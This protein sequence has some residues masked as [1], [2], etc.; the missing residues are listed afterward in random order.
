MQV[1]PRNP[2]VAAI[3]ERMRGG[4][5]EDRAG[6]TPAAPYLH[7]AGAA[8]TAAGGLHDPAHTDRYLSQYQHSGDRGHLELHRTVA[9]RYGEAH[10]S[11]HREERPDRSEEHT[12]E[13]QSHS[14]LVCR[15]LL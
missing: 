12:S 6:R 13:L 9:G 15:L 5:H 1:L 4:F 8:D 11:A 7:R 3:A 10:H 2:K 14:D